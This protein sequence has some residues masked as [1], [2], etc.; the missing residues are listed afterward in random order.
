MGDIKWIKIYTN[1]FDNRKI[2]QIEALP[3]GDVLIVIW[4]KLLCLAGETN[5]NGAIYITREVPYTIEMLTTAFNRPLA[6]IK[7]ALSTFEKFQMIEI[8]DEVIKVSNW[9]KYQNIEGMEKV[10][11]QTKE[12]VRKYRE[13]QKELEEKTDS[14]VTVTL[15]NAIDKEKEI[16]N[17]YN[18][19]VINNSHI[20][21]FEG[22][23]DCKSPQIPPV[24]L[25]V[26]NFW[27]EKKIAIHRYLT[28]AMVRKID[29]AL[30]I[31][32][33]DQIKEAIEHYAEVYHADYYLDY[34]WT[35][36]EF[37]SQSNCLPAFLTGGKHWV[38]Y[39]EKVYGETPED[40]K[41]EEPKNGGFSEL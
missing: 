40:E 27:N 22:E 33:L 6:T 2:K 9:E 24:F 36:E 35:L 20:V 19:R 11:E 30:K 41:K 1:V 25:E 10:R 16:D 13:K 7:L 32:G 15:R 31:Y 23:S 18:I 4:F 8:I 21:P 17:I 37:L 38:N 34:K 12:R 14:N 39:R 29:K 5:D 26:F 28:E 3:D